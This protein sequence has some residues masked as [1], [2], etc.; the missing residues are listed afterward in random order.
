MD[1]SSPKFPKS[2]S[3]LPSKLEQI[4][5]VLMR[6]GFDT[7]KAFAE[8]L[9]IHPDTVRNFRQGRPVLRRTFQDICE[10]LELEPNEWAFVGGDAA[11]ALSV[12][13]SSSAQEEDGEADVVDATFEELEE[14]EE[15]ASEENDQT[16]EDEVQ[17]ST[18]NQVVQTVENNPGLMIGN[19]YGNVSFQPSA[20]GK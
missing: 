19:V 13:A 4:D 1:S 3:L 10:V 8:A 9:E 16:S 17:K 11:S 15:P 5:Q 12:P 7:L 6:Q 18:G 14:L 20:D 2:L